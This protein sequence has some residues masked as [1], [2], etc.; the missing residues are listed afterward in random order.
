MSRQEEPVRYLSVRDVAQRLGVS[1]ELVRDWCNS[2][3]LS[4]HRLGRKGKRGRIK[5]ALADLDAYLAST[6]QEKPSEPETLPLSPPKVHPRRNDDFSQYCER[7]RERA[8]SKR[9]F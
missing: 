6:R 2:G 1:E 4:H 7:V 3:E 8:N 9:R 5:I